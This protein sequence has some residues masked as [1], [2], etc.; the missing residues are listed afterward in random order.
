MLMQTQLR[1]IGNSRGLIIPSAFLESCSLNDKVDLRVEG[2]TLIIEALKKPR[3][4]W[5]DNYQAEKNDEAWNDT[6][7]DDITEEWEW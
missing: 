3:A 6:L 2:K 7:P 5:F 1:K 4:K